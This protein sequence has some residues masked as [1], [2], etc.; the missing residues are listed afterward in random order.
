MNYNLSLNARG[1]MLL[2]I[3]VIGLFEVANDRCDCKVFDEI[4]Q[5]IANI[6]CSFSCE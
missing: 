5:K 6:A 2:Q 1:C 4:F 3:F